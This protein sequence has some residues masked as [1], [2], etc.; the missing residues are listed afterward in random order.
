MPTCTKC[1]LEVE[2]PA[3]VCAAC[4][5]EPAPPDVAPTPPPVPEMEMTAA[6]PPPLRPGQRAQ[7]G[8]KKGALLGAIYGGAY[9]VIMYLVIAAFTDGTEEHLLFKMVVTHA[10]LVAAPLAV[11]G[12]VLGYLIPPK[13]KKLPPAEPTDAKP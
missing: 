10:L 6:E 1:G 8:A 2:A 7:A 4:A 12:G 3:T 9:G 5:L 11:I 13:K